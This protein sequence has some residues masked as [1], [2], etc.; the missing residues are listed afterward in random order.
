MTHAFASIAIGTAASLMTLTLLLLRVGL[1]RRN[2]FALTSRWIDAG[3]STSL[4]VLTALL[5]I[6]AGSFASLQ[7]GGSSG[8]DSSGPIADAPDATS[9]GNQAL[10]S[11]AAYAGNIDDQ[12]GPP[13]AGAEER[14]AK[15][16][17]A[18]DVMVAK[19]IARLKD[20]PNDVAGWKMLG[21]SYLNT[22]RPAD[23]VE[24]YQTA[25]KLEPGNI[26][27]E[28]ALNAAKSQLAGEPPATNVD[29]AE[30]GVSELDD[31]QSAMIRDMVD[32]LATRLETSP[33]D[34]EG[35]AQLMRSRM[36]QG[37]R[38]AA[39]TALAKALLVFKSDAAASER[40]TSVARG[41]GIDIPAAQ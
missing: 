18:V 7:L 22:N 21:W 1:H 12:K 41:L 6:A 5:V 16:L 25:L 26:E 38:D 14:D 40:L 28:K 10:Q 11:L 8:G 30:R 37:E 4:L 34:E 27:A 17:P 32:R 23:A 29:N 24:A 36:V 35:W 33:G 13:H 31:N 19:L 3:R 9:N 15:D 2:V 39:K 20:Q